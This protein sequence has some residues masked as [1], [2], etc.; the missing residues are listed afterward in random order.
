[1]FAGCGD[2]GIVKLYL[3][4]SCRIRKILAAIR[5]MPILNIAVIYARSVNRCNMRHIVRNFRNS[6]FRQLVCAGFVRIV[7]VAYRAMPILY[8]TL[9]RTRRTHCVRVRH[10]VR[11]LRRCHFGQLLFTGFVRIVLAA[12]RAMPIGDIALFGASSL[13]SLDKI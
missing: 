12:Y 13:F 10:I 2:Y 1:M 9:R 7:L 4:L 5:A 3:A 6:H 8:V 11:Y